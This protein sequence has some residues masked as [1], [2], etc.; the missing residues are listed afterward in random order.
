M[1]L[2]IYLHD[3]YHNYLSLYGDINTVVDRILTQLSESDIDIEAIHNAPPRDGAKRVNINVTNEWYL[4]ELCARPIN[5]PL[6]SLRKILYY[7][8]DNELPSEWGWKTVNSYKNRH[9]E[10]IRKHLDSAISMLI[11]AKY[12]TPHHIG[13]QLSSIIEQVQYIRSQYDD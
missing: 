2:S 11:H 7:V 8:V 5:S 12:L 10:R 6:Y 1:R 3:E 4:S 13:E 9:D